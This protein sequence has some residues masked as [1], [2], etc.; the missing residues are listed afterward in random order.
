MEVSSLWHHK[1]CWFLTATSSRL[2]GNTQELV[3]LLL[4]LCCPQ[5]WKVQNISL[6]RKI[7][8]SIFLVVA[9]KIRYARTRTRVQS[10][11]FKDQVL[12]DGCKQTK[13]SVK[14][15]GKSNKRCHFLCISGRQR[16]TFSLI[17]SPIWH[18]DSE[19]AAFSGSTTAGQTQVGRPHSCVAPDRKLRNQDVDIGSHFLSLGERDRTGHALVASRHHGN[20]TRPPRKFIAFT[21]VK[22]CAV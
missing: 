22:R 14:A 5:M 17:Y 21:Q 3:P 1:V 10:V 18:Y 12:G 6:S 15:A 16:Q 9:K 7:K 13:K 11:A 20:K 4:P 2:S 8:C 19:V